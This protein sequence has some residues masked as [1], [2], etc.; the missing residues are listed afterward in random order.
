MKKII[1]ILLV[2]ILISCAKSTYYAYEYKHN[3]YYNYCTLEI[4]EKKEVIYRASAD[5]YQ[6]RSYPYS[7]LYIYIYSDK[8]ATDVNKNHYS[9]VSG[10][11]EL[12]LIKTDLKPKLEHRFLDF[13]NKPGYSVLYRI[14]DEIKDTIFSTA[15]NDFEYL[16]EGTGFE[17]NGI[18]WFPP[19]M[20]KI[21]KIDYTKFHKSIQHLNLKNPKK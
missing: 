4:T 8:D 11:S 3:D 5:Y 20:V 15:D 17:T 21:D 13:G 10:F 14:D 16:K 6:S 2:F 7:N 9:F 18:K 19:Y 1:L 12:Y